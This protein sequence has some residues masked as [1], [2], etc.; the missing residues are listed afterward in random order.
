MS[1]RGCV[2]PASVGEVCSGKE[3]PAVGLEAVVRRRSARLGGDTPEREEG[4]VARI[5]GVPSGCGWR[6]IGVPPR[7]INEIVHGRRSITADAATHCSRK[8]SPCGFL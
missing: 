6:G 4:R 7:R 5:G 2:L 8:R 1:G 3:W